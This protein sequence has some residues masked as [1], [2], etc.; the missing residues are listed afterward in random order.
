[1]AL[2]ALAAERAAKEAAQ[3]EEAKARVVLGFFEDRVIVPARPEGLE[4]GLGHDITLGQAVEVALPFVR[5]TFRD[6][7][8]VEARLRVTR[9]TS[10]LSRGDARKA[11]EQ[12]EAARALHARHRG[13]DHPDTLA[14]MNHLANS[15]AALGRHADALVLREQTLELRKARLGADHPDT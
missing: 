14:S 5:S 2:A 11:A 9:G 8:L 10:L 12:Y 3:A 13:P 4:G 15:Y 7:P 6:Q 1:Q